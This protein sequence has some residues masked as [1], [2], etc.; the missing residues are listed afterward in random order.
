MDDRLNILEKKFQT[1]LVKDDFKC[2][3]DYSIK[4]LTDYG[5]SNIRSSSYNKDTEKKKTNNNFSLR[6]IF[7]FKKK[8]VLTLTKD[9]EAKIYSDSNFISLNISSFV[10]DDDYI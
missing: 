8:K 10:K 4:M 9:E 7:S 1:K 5:N 3:D 2:Q 6:N